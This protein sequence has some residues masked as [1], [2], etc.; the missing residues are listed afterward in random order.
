MR[1][2]DRTLSC[3]CRPGDLGPKTSQTF[4]RQPR[5][6]SPYY[7]PHLTS[8]RQGVPDAGG[9]LLRGPE[10]GTGCGWVAGMRW[11]SEDFGSDSCD[12]VGW[13]SNIFWTQPVQAD[14]ELPLLKVRFPNSPPHYT[15]PVPKPRTSDVAG[16]EVRVNLWE[17]PPVAARRRIRGVPRRLRVA[18]SRRTDSTPAHQGLLP[19]RGWHFVARKSIIA[20]PSAVVAW[21]VQVSSASSYCSVGLPALF[22]GRFA[23]RGAA[24]GAS[25]S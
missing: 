6:P 13:S 19:Q 18:L 1:G 12:V 2:G 22:E 24:T 16:S 20:L 11:R 3:C 25:A 17:S 7:G 14:R 9:E 4:D 5:L 23:V 10:G 15:R 8:T 21:D